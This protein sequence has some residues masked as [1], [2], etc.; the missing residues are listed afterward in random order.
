M[1]SGASPTTI[2]RLSQA[3]TTTFSLLRG[4]LHLSA[5]T[6]TSGINTQDA[7]PTVMSPHH[8]ITLPWGTL[9]RLAA[10][11]FTSLADLF[12]S[13]SPCA[14]QLP[15]TLGPTGNWDFP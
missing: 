14:R 12:A 3:T 11:Y 2:S 1:L 10:L 15:G 9:H 7:W 6:H 5:Y 13:L 4:R 8:C